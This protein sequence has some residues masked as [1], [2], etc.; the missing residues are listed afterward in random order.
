VLGLSLLTWTVR[1]ERE[2]IE[3]L[4]HAD[5]VVFEGFKPPAPSGGTNVSIE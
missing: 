4:R 2:R 1:S 5:Q 3:A